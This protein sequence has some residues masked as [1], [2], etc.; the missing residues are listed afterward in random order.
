MHTI[1]RTTGELHWTHDASGNPIKGEVVDL[2]AHKVAVCAKY[3][4]RPAPRQPLIL[5]IYGYDL[6][7]SHQCSYKLVLD[8][9]VSLTGKASGGSFPS[10]DLQHV[11]M[12]DV[13][14][15]KLQ[16]YPDSA[17]QDDATELDAAVFGILSSS[18]FVADNAMARPGFPFSYAKEPKR[19][20]RTKWSSSASHFQ[21]AGLEVYVVDTSRYWQELVD[22]RSLVHESI[23]GIRKADRSILS[24]EDVNAFTELVANF[25][26]WINHC[27]A[28]IFHI[29]GYR[30]G[31]LVYRGY[32]L[33][34][35]ATL[36]RDEFSWFPSQ[37]YRCENVNKEIT[38]EIVS[39]DLIQLLGLFDEKW[40]DNAD[41]KDALH[42]ALQMLRGGDKGGPNQPPSINYMRDTCTACAIAE[43]MLT[44][45]GGGR[46]RQ[47]ARCLKEINVPDQLPGPGQRIAQN[48]PE[49][50]WTKKK[51]KGEDGYVNEDERAKATMSR[52]MANITNWLL[53]LENPD[54]ANRL[55]C[56]PRNVQHYMVEVTTWLADLLLMKVV[57]YNGRYLDRLDLTTKKVP[58]S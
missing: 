29:K 40:G 4:L 3:E 54:N 7:A 47:I 32:E 17:D 5:D 55:L 51:D 11:S 22:N 50:W 23:V 1:F 30:G 46:R 27:A 19:P 34:P 45:G 49:L 8:N 15:G 37:W 13:D 36:Q 31:R 20:I 16:L 38:N 43:R 53:H 48:H 52:P 39:E 6:L 24:W 26:G 12:Y 44:G 10:K 33:Y 58:W 41:N 14:L 28:P 18:P 25:I 56:L 21:Y 2:L 9:G 35:H 57:G 42:V